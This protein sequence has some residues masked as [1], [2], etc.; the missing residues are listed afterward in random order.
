MLF[1]LCLSVL[2]YVFFS[3]FVMC[4]ALFFFFGVFALIWQQSL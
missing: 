3:L 2:N 1:L 4:E